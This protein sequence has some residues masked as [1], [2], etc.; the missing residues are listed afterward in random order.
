[1][2]SLNEH[3]EILFDHLGRTLLACAMQV[4]LF[5]VARAR[6]SRVT[7]RPGAVP[8]DIAVLRVGQATSKR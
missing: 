5:G 3:G 1:M 8:G 4:V 2:A 6:G 7:R